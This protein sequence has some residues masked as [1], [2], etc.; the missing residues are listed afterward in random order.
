MLLV[1]AVEDFWP[2]RAQ[3][4]ISPSPHLCCCLQYSSEKQLR[5]AAI[6]TVPESL[7]A[8]QAQ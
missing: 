1:A 2:C 3:R 7:L 4:L 5:V 6:Y 8:P